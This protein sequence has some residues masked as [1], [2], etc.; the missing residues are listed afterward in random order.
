MFPNDPMPQPQMPQEAD[1][2]MGQDMG[3]E[4]APQEDT[5]L[6]DK[7]LGSTNIAES[8]LKK[9]GGKEQL[10][11]IAQTCIE[12]YDMDE[13]SRAN[14]LAQNEEY[15]KLATQVMEKKSYPW[16]GASNVKYPMLT[17]AALQFSS[18]AYGSLISGFDVVKAKVVG[19][20][21][22]GKGAVDAT[23]ISTH[24][25]YQLLYEM[26][27]WEEGMD[28]LC[29]ILPIIGTAFKKTYY[30]PFLQKNCSELVLARDLTINYHA[31]SIEEAYRKTHKIWK[32]PN[33]IVSYQRAGI[34][35]E[36]DNEALL[37]G[38]TSS[39]DQ[40]G[41]N[42]IDAATSTNDGDK[43]MPR[44]L[45]EQHTFLDLDDDGYEEPYIIT[46]DKDTATVL[47]IVARFYRD[48]VALDKDGEVIS[49]TPC[50][51]FTKYGFIP[52]PDGGFY[53]L[54][55]GLLLGG[56]N[57]A[58]NTAINQ[59]IDAGTI[60]NLQAGFISKGIRIKQ[61]EMKFKPGEWKWVNSGLDDLS[62]GIVALP[63][64]DPSNVLFQL[65]G[66]LIQSGKEL[67]SIAEIFTGKMPGQNTPASTT[68]A[69]I[70]QG[71]KVFTSIYKRI[72]RSMGEEFQKLYKLNQLYLPE[73]TSFTYEVAGE[74]KH[75]TVSK[76]AYANPVQGAAPPGQPF[77]RI[78][79]AA[80][81]NM[82]SDTQKLLRS[83]GLMELM[84]TRQINPQEAVRQVLENQGQP[85]I[86]QLLMPPSPPPIPPEI[87]FKMKEHTDRM[88]LEWAQFEL[89]TVTKRFES[90]K[91]MAEV[92]KLLAEAE[93]VG[94]ETNLASLQHEL[95][96]LEQS[97][98][99]YQN[100]LDRVFKSREQAMAQ[101]KQQQEAA[102]MQQQAQAQ[103][104]GQ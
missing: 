35:L 97:E 55:F 20:D 86:P 70:E 75:G 27:G 68:M 92:K 22:E 13:R 54:G 15:M 29:F 2:M 90:I 8:I 64:R 66:T 30:D 104:Q 9:K 24:M 89:E 43:S 31:Q 72:Y 100:S 10:A 12:G 17:T 46:I 44:L 81:P 50:E 71:L 76:E 4:P 18:R 40:V 94:E 102:A 93:A 39:G 58:A 14:W 49:I 7:L 87:E 23:A 38:G 79:P 63:V 53:D 74:D 96:I 83:Q 6:I 82:V 33:E 48:G 65:L 84:P 37:S 34:F 52:N 69:T 28:K 11:K 41:P 59:L 16:D 51:Y 5:T 3:Q 1:P 57:A 45:L 47:R 67:A 103:K 77:V 60:A 98:G 25:S 80:D 26:R 62:K 21:P 61:G 101:Q 78:V 99:V 56:L 19:A 91:R 88:E 32:T 95:Q 73:R 85:N 36:T 42:K